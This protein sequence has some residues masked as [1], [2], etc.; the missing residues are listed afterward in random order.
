MTRMNAER[1]KQT[2]LVRMIGHSMRMTP[3]MD[4]SAKPT[5]V[6]AYMCVEIASVSPVLTIFHACGTKL[7]FEQTDAT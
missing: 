2:T 7:V 4:Q 1:Q 3:K 5:T 6:T